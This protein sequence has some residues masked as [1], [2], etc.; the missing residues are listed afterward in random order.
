MIFLLRFLLIF[1]C[2]SVYVEVIISSKKEQDFNETK[3]REYFDRYQATMLEK[4]NDAPLAVL[5]EVSDEFVQL[6]VTV[7]ETTKNF[8][9]LKAQA[10]QPNKRANINVSKKKNCTIFDDDFWI[11]HERISADLITISGALEF[12][13]VFPKLRCLR[14][15]LFLVF[16][17]PSPSESYFEPY[18]SM[19]F[20]PVQ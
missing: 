8:H 14:V 13:F 11:L 5:Y 10:A 17:T 18:F 20:F 15:V 2:S 1:R 16:T 7:K 12:F 4:M 6:F 19:F 9:E 3:C